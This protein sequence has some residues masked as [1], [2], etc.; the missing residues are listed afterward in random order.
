[1]QQILPGAQPDARVGVIL[2]SCILFFTFEYLQ[3]NTSAVDAIGAASIEALPRLVSEG[4]P[5]DV[6]SVTEACYFLLRANVFQISFSPMYLSVRPRLLEI[7]ASES[8]QPPT[9]LGPEKSTQEFLAMWWRFV[10]TVLNFTIYPA[11]LRDES[12][13]PKPW[14]RTPS[15]LAALDSW[16]RAA[17]HRATVCRDSDA[18]R[19]LQAVAVLA[20]RLSLALQARRVST[21]TLESRDYAGEFPIS[22]RDYSAILEFFKTSKKPPTDGAGN[23]SAEAF[24]I[25]N[26]G[27]HDAA[28][29]TLLYVARRCPYYA[30]R[31][32]ALDLCFAL[33]QPA[34]SLSLK[35]TYMALRALAEIEGEELANCYAWTKGSWNDDY[36]GLRITLSPVD[37]EKHRIQAIHLIL[38]TKDYGM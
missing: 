4:T 10:T 20:G 37:P 34:P 26:E 24:V 7:T 31:L 2:T 27:A 6:K 19:L 36:T 15:L 17:R 32:E 8:L 9:A 13:T 16:E 28:L 11:T 21:R 29:P 33:L 14:S 5:V 22:P 35:A 3:D 38:S 25:N 12:T 1:M 30:I 18:I 23:R